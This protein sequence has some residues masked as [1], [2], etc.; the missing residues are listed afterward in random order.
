MDDRL[1]NGCLQNLR[2]QIDELERH[3]TELVGRSGEPIHAGQEEVE[4]YISDLQDLLG[5]GSIV[6]RKTFLRSWIKRITL[7]GESGGTIE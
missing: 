3:K 7:D 4:T 5:K 2:A 6:E 1:I